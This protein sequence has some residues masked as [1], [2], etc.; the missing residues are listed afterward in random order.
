MALNLVF[1]SESWD[2]V[3]V[4]ISVV[5]LGTGGAERFATTLANE[6]TKNGDEVI[7]LCSYKEPSFHYE[8]DEKVRISEVF[9]KERYKKGFKHYLSVLNR[10]FIVRK[11]IKLEK[12]D[13]IFS[14]Y[15]NN[16]TQDTISTIGLG[17]PIIIGE[18]D[19][20]F[21]NDGK[22][23][24]IIRKLIYS[25]VSGLVY[26]TEYAKE[27]L[28]KY[29]VNSRE[30]IILKNPVYIES[31]PDEIEICS[32]EKIICAG[33]LDRN[34]N[35]AGI[36]K[37]FSI[38]A[39]KHQHITLE[40]YGDG[41]E[42]DNLLELTREL[43]I[44]NQVFLR[45]ETNNIVQVLAGASCFVLFSNQE[46]YPNVLLEAMAVG[47]PVIASNCPVGA[48]AELIK[49][50]DNGFLVPV[51]DI[52]ELSKK[53]DMM[54]RNTERSKEMALMARKVRY[55]NEKIRIIERFRGFLDSLVRC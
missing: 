53:M 41:P 15:F 48:C 38:I 50:G 17:T 43:K 49:E 6:L 26:Q 19:A 9:P 8:L 23:K 35:F 28:N 22:V 12:P 13:V 20:F 37:A 54:L 27:L 40:I 5:L 11:F 4:V 1:I 3:K 33:R 16:S 32:K 24:N 47:V 7:I 46:G 14:F 34:K 10:M 42:I 21:L 25:R 52:N 45:G 2:K 36:I 51:G 39:Y 29:N 31:Y 18:R 30:T 44:E 55:D